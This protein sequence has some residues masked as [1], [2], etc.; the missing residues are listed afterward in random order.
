MLFSLKCTNSWQ[1]AELISVLH[2]INITATPLRFWSPKKSAVR[3]CFCTCAKQKHDKYKAYSIRQQQQSPALN[4]QSKRNLFALLQSLIEYSVKVCHSW[5][6]WQQKFHVSFFVYL[7]SEDNVSEVFETCFHVHS[8]WPNPAERYAGE[9]YTGW[10]AQGITMSV[11]HP[12]MEAFSR[13][14]WPTS[15]VTF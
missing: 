15:K 4:L 12:G 2:K 1:V 11:P 10:F 14:A 3:T 6:P 5:H 8:F 7:P 13:K 9:S